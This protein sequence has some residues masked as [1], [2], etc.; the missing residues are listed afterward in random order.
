MCNRMCI[1]LCT[2]PQPW[3]RG[4]RDRMCINLCASRACPPYL[5]ILAAALPRCRAHGFKNVRH[6]QQLRQYWRRATDRTIAQQRI[7]PEPRTYVTHPRSSDD[8]LKALLRVDHDC[9]RQ[10]G[11]KLQWHANTTPSSF[12]RTRRSARSGPRQSSQTVWLSAILSTAS[13][14]S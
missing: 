3:A 9:C 6:G 13:T 2:P 4:V 12:S 5:R 11:S 1:T 10:D 7:D 14:C 8:R